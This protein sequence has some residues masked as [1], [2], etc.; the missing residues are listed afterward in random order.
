MYPGAI[1][2]YLVDKYGP[3]LKPP[4]S[5]ED[6]HLRY[7]YWLHFGDGRQTRLCQKCLC[8]IQ[9]FAFGLD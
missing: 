7:I 2:E 5:D 9:E 8:T 3:Q 1:I 4:Q 6:L